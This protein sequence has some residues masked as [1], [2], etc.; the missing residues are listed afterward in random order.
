MLQKYFSAASQSHI[1][2]SGKLKEQ[3]TIIWL[4]SLEGSD[5]GRNEK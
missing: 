5:C 2:E 1:L 3:K 4:E